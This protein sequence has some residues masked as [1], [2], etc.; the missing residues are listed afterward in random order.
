MISHRFQLLN[1]LYLGTQASNHFCNKTFP[2]T[3]I[4]SL[5]VLSFKAIAVLFPDFRNSSY[6]KQ[7]NVALPFRTIDWTSE[8][9]FGSLPSW[10]SRLGRSKVVVMSCVFLF[11]QFSPVFSPSLSTIFSPIFSPI[12]SPILLP[13][14]DTINGENWEET[15]GE[16]R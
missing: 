7:P 15:R 11:I 8:S 10:L 13:L 2:G 9:Y 1:L 16:D 3:I 4:K 6:V 12:C 5:T 14:V